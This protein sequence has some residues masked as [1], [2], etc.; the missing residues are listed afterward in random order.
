[1]ARI[2]IT[3]FSTTPIRFFTKYFYATTNGGTQNI[4]D[5]TTTSAPITSKYYKDY[6]AIA[7]LIN[8]L[9]TE[10]VLRED[11]NDLLVP[12]G[13]MLVVPDTLPSDKWPLVMIGHGNAAGYF[14]VDDELTK[15]VLDGD[16]NVVT[17]GEWKFK[18]FDNN[19][20]DSYAGYASFQDHLASQGIASFSFNLN[21]VNSI[22]NSEA[23]DFDRLKVDVN[24]RIQLFFLHLK[25]LKILAGDSLTISASGDEFPIKFFDG[26]NLVNLTDALTDTTSPDEFVMMLK[27]V[28]TSHVDFSKLGIMGHSRGADMVTRIPAY[29]YRGGTI[30]GPTFDVNTEVNRRIRI[31]S[32]QL[33]KPEQDTLKIIFALEPVA[34]KNHVNANNHGYVIN[35]GQTLY[36]VGVGTHDEDVSLDPVRIYEYPQCPKIMIAINGGSHKRFNSVWYEIEKRKKPEKNPL[37]QPKVKLNLLKFEKQQAILQKVYGPC[38]IATLL[39]RPALLL[40]IVLKKL[41]IDLPDAINFQMAWKFGL[42]LNLLNSPGSP[43]KVLKT[44][45]FKFEQ[46]DLE[47]YYI[48]KN[49]EGNAV[50]KVPISGTGINLTNFTHFSFRFAKGFS[51]SSKPERVEEKNFTMQCFENDTPIGKIITGA[52]IDTVELKALQAFDEARKVNTKPE[53][54]YSILLQTMEIALSSFSRTDLNR[55]TRIDITVIPDETKPPPNHAS[56]IILGSVGGAIMGAFV[57]SLGAAIMLAIINDDDA[58]RESNTWMGL[59]GA[60]GAFIGGGKALYH[61][62]PDDN[63]FVF[64]D[65][66]LTNRP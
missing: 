39:D 62:L 34:T 11:G 31:I 14:E 52:D 47:T 21:I 27:D 32:E 3:L 26:S 59:A 50:I 48:E 49:N 43:E 42:A 66:L 12:L 54:T 40:D 65:F 15:P 25:L 2:P 24:Q 57:G 41:D 10:N 36:M 55:V 28:L 7:T 8:P 38:F 30:N 64:E 20:V 53:F 16:G 61:F 19:E 56:K 63:A 23:K 44:S 18:R 5:K 46:E 35:N 29:F 13:G 22:E 58:K 4:F 17:K 1:M 9:K 51:L 33:S 45:S 37:E 60:L 6:D